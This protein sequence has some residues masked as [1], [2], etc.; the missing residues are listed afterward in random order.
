MVRAP[1]SHRPLEDHRVVVGARSA[2]AKIVD[3]VDSRAAVA[4][5]CDVEKSPGTRRNKRSKPKKKRGK[6]SRGLI[7]KFGYLARRDGS[8]VLW[9]VRQLAIGS[10]ERI[11]FDESR[12]GARVVTLGGTKVGFLICGEMMAKR[13]G[14]RFRCGRFGESVLS[15]ADLVVDVAH[16]D[17]KT[18]RSQRTWS[19][20]LSEVAGRGRPLVMAQHLWVD[21]VTRR[22]TSYADE[23]GPKRLNYG[24]SSS[25]RLAIRDRNG[26]PLAY[27]DFYDV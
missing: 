21:Y 4:F 15:S 3:T 1:L 12:D 24:I 25:D 18:G 8:K 23:S 5:G 16:S 22:V 26:S 27:L 14:R 7:P 9:H 6:K 20:A 11:P 10:T 19:Q 17:I 2:A 13:M